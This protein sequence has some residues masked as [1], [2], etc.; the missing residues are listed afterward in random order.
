MNEHELTA[1]LRLAAA[2]LWPLAALHLAGTVN[3][4]RAQHAAAL[5]LHR[6]RP[7]NGLCAEC[8][9]MGERHPCPTARA[10]GVTP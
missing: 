4:L 1:T 5:A 3:A 8:E 6:R 7:D 10:L 9:E 2:G